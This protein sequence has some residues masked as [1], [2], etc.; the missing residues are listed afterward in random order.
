MLLICLFLG[1][2][3]WSFPFITDFHLN[4]R[5]SALHQAAERGDL[6]EVKR[7][8]GSGIDVN[9]LDERGETPLWSAIPMKHFE[10][11]NFLVSNGAK[12]DLKNNFGQT[13]LDQC[14]QHSWT[15]CTDWFK[16][17]STRD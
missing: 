4:N 12:T 16:Q 2:A 13:L 15:E 9:I 8:V 6:A 3:G 10:I 5:Q 14:Q 1:I 7:L 17:R 11:A